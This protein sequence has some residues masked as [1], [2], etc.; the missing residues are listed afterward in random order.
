MRVS[1]KVQLSLI[2]SRQCAFHWAID[3][4]CALPTSTQRVAQYL[5][6]PFISS[7]QVIV[8]TSNL[9]RG[10]NIASTRISLERLKLETKNLVQLCTLIIASPSLRTTNCPW[11]GRGHCHVTSLIFWKISGN[12]SKTVRDSLIVSINLNTKSYALYRMIMLPM[13]LGNP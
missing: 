9:A 1:K 12:I 5:A 3:E 2:G 11:K 4:L 8:D 6:L 10:L 7:L 13:T